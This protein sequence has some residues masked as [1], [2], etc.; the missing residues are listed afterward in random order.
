MATQ[1]TT[2]IPELSND[3]T[4]NGIKYHAGKNVIVPKESADDIIRIDKDFQQ[5]ERNLLVKRT[6]NVDSGTF[7]VGNGAE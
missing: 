4:I 5:Y 1:E 2:T 7:S 3:V 6:S